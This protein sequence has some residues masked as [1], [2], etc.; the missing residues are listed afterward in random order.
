MSA[1]RQQRGITLIEV[2]VSI[3]ILGLALIS[4]A[5]LQSYTVKYQLGSA[6]RAVLSMLVSDFS[7][8]VRAN[9]EAAPGGSSAA[10]SSSPYLLTATW[11]EQGAA[12]A[13]P[14]TDCIKVGCA[15]AATLAQWDMALWRQRVREE[16]PRGSAQVR[17]TLQNG[18]DVTIMWQDNELG[19]VSPVCAA[20]PTPAEARNCCPVSLPAGVRC[21]N[22]L[23]LP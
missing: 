17:G 12:P 16:L 21:A 22:F 5:G 2:L 13:A 23:I 10:A 18:M 7:E 20:N 9:R 11:A 3:L 15:D 6:N 4:L 19:S 8:R 14:G 1:L